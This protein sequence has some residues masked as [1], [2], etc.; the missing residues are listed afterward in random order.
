MNS[1]SG[2]DGRG[3]NRGGRLEREKRTIRHMLAIYCAAHHRHRVGLCQECRELLDYALERI[4]R[5]PYGGRKPACN[6]CPIHCYRRCERE[7]IRR[8][9]RYAGPRMLLRHPLLALLHL[10]DGVLGGRGSMG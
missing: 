1:L 5:C 6:A 7:E 2:R 8:V 9:M 4:E 10:L 3:G